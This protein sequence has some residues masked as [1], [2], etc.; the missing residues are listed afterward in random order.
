GELLNLPS[1]VRAEREHREAV[2]R[3]MDA[4]DLAPYRTAPVA[5]LPYGVR[6]MV[7]LA[8]ALASQPR[9]ILLDEPA[10]GLNPEET[11]DLAFW[12]ED[13]RRDW[14]VTIVMV[15]HDMSLVGRVADRVL[16]MN[17]GEVLAL[18]TAAEVNANPAVIEAYLGV[19][20]G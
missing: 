18:G 4:L 2:E 6:K 14:G 15:E 5:G 10:S 17:M 11:H 1:V 12:L 19:A 8:R 20:H 3:V 7:E 9:L 13:L 16:C